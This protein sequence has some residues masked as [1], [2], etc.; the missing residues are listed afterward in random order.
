MLRHLIICNQKW[1]RISAQ[2]K[3]SQ[4]PSVGHQWERIWGKWIIASWVFQLCFW[5]ERIKV[6][7]AFLLASS[8]F[9]VV[10]Y[11]L[12]RATHFFNCE[13]FQ[14]TPTLSFHFQH[15]GICMWILLSLRLLGRWVSLIRSNRPTHSSHLG[16][17]PYKNGKIAGVQFLGKKA[18]VVCKLVKMTHT[19]SS[20][21]PTLYEKVSHWLLIW[22][23]WRKIREKILQRLNHNH[24]S[25]QVSPQPSIM[26][27]YFPLP[28]P[29]LAFLDLF[30]LPLQKTWGTCDS[31]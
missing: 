1:W 13:F 18:L 4:D 16:I 7:K 3:M 27:Q 6:Y 24:S 10:Y 21:M 19:T 29:F 12:K 25:W 8:V 11:I 2:I 15:L 17:K 20:S 28:L 14:Y 23:Y 5:W 30:G 22:S 31:L 9:I 26:G